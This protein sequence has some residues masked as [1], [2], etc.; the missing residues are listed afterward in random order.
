MNHLQ[1]RPA[2]EDDAGACAR[3]MFD[4]FESLATRHACRIEPGTPEFTDCQMTAML[5]TMP[6]R[7]FCMGSPPNGL[8]PE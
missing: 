5:A 2:T 1:I 8:L 3:I 4:A 6:S 7:R